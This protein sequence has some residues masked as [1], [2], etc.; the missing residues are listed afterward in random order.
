MRRP[1]G[2]GATPSRTP[3]ASLPSA[4]I[5]GVCATLVLCRTLAAQESV[6]AP[7]QPTLSADEAEYDILR[8][9]LGLP[10]PAPAVAPPELP[11][12]ESDDSQ[13]PAKE[14]TERIEVA[15]AAVPA[16]PPAAKKAP[17]PAPK[18]AT[19]PASAPKKPAPPPKK[20]PAPPPK[21][22]PAPA[23]V[24]KQVPA[25]KS[26]PSPAPPVAPKSVPV[27]DIPEAGTV[28]DGSNAERWKH[29]LGPSIH[30]AIGRGATLEV[31]DAEPL[32]LEAK[33]EEATQRY[34]S[35]VRLTEDRLA[36]RDYVAGIPFPLVT[37]E[38]PD[39]AI[40]V[41]FNYEARLVVDDV[42]LRRS[43]CD[44]GGLDAERGV[45]V[46]R[47]YE[48]EHFRRLFYVSRL[49][50]EPMP[51]WKTTDDVRYREVAGPLAEPFDLK[52]AGYTY[53]RYLDP[54]RQDDSWVYYPSSRRVRRLSTA[55]RSEGIFG[56]DIDLDSFAGFAGNP[57]WTEWK[58]LGRKTVLASL[59][60]RNVPARFQARPA[61][62]FPDDVWEPREVHIIVGTS[63]LPGNSFGRRVLYVDREA[64]LIP[65]A[66]L[67]D[68]KGGMWKSLVQ[69][70]ST[71]KNPAASSPRSDPQT[72]IASISLYDMQ[73]DHVTRC[74]LPSSMTVGEQGWYFNFG[75]GEGTT[76]EEFSVQG[77]ISRGR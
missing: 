1:F 48:P 72:F 17:A 28:V 43:V 52:G 75:D 33:R 11:E 25:P 18:K 57:A 77:M 30:W 20:P 51:T 6:P 22:A 37:D 31:I 29:L 53:I 47:H 24:R 8:K 12:A 46:E 70:W 21:R 14:G 54:R 23:P 61:D 16:A 66:E 7:P 5:F 50:N 4:F 15:P 69:T 40:K 64:L 27:P 63:R 44:T 55:Q 56:Q 65:Y 67:Y 2:R 45:T 26:A 60:A 41:M 3:R 13:A 71:Q 73:L 58:Y 42:D 74:E 34:H 39:L 10:I 59:H 38:D 76:E 35:Q 68:R 36:L 32:P 62:F 49:Y 9:L 19:A